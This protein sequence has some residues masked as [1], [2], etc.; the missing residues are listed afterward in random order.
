MFYKLI[1]FAVWRL[2]MAYLRQR[3]GRALRVAA[4]LGLAGV[5]AGGYALTR[6]N[7]D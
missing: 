1:G 7:G 3:Y 2:A 6:S 4:L 5:A